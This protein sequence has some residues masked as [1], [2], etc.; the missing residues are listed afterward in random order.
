MKAQKKVTTHPTHATNA[1]RQ[2]D[3]PVSSSCSLCEESGTKCF[4]C[5][6]LPNICSVCDTSCTAVNLRAITE[7][8]GDIQSNPDQMPEFCEACFKTLSPADLDS[9]LQ[10]ALDVN[11]RQTG[12]ST[13]RQTAKS[14][15]H[16][17]R[18]G[19]VAVDFP[20]MGYV[21]DSSYLQI[22]HPGETL[23]V[24]DHSEVLSREIVG[25]YD[26][27]KERRKK[28]R[29]GVRQRIALM[30]DLAGKLASAKRG[31]RQERRQK[32]HT[33]RLRALQQPIR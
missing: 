14:T 3:N 24:A 29:L 30:G 11:D 8:P 17:T 16:Q 9:R 2:T 15:F 27:P 12:E 10:P 1:E 33:H 7:L 28:E 23:T 5:D 25:K 26:G 32:K 18:E 19:T 31:N 21:L 4:L 13:V 22:I 6:G 20:G